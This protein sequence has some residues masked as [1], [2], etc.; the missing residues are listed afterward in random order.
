MKIALDVEGTLADIHTMFLKRYNEKNSTNYS[1][2]DIKWDF[3]G[4]EFSIEEFFKRTRKQWKREW[5]KIPGTEENISKALE[6]IKNFDKIKLD[7]V[8]SR[9]GCEEGMKNWLEKQG[10]P[11]SEFMVESDKHKLNYDVYIDDNPNLSGKVENLLLYRRPW[12]REIDN[13]ED[14]KIIEKFDKIPKFMDK[15]ID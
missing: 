14:T 6:K 15:I 4:I 8:T 13:S 1:L 3:G 5:K 9:E 12:N 10:I 2:E 11:Y 7:I